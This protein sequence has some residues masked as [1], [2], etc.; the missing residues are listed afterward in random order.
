[1]TILWARYGVWDMVGEDIRSRYHL[2]GE[3]SD[4]GNA[5]GD[6]IMDSRTEFGANGWDKL[7]PGAEVMCEVVTGDHFSIMRKPGVLEVGKRLGEAVH[8]GL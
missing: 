2:M 4:N 1:V 6:W 8:R 5:A 3:V 7:L